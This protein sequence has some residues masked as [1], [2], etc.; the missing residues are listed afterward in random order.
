MKKQVPEG[1]FTREEQ[2]AELRKKLIGNTAF[3]R[4][5]GILYDQNTILSLF[6]QASQ[7]K[8]TPTQFCRKLGKITK[9]LRVMGNKIATL[10]RDG[11]QEA[12]QALLRALTVPGY[13]IP[14]EEI[15]L[16]KTVPITLIMFM[17]EKCMHMLQWIIEGDSSDL[18]THMDCRKGEKPY[19]RQELTER[20]FELFPS[21]YAGC[22]HRLLNQRYEG[23]DLRYALY[24]DVTSRFSI[25]SGFQPLH[26]NH[27]QYNDHTE[28]LPGVYDSDHIEVNNEDVPCMGYFAFWAE[29]DQK[30]AL[31][32][33]S[34]EQQELMGTWQF[35]VHP[36]VLKKVKEAPVFGLHT[37]DQ[38][39]EWSHSM[40][41]FESAGVSHGYGA[42]INPDPKD[43]DTYRYGYP[44]PKVKG[45]RV[46]LTNYNPKK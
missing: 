24:K 17:P 5:R 43:Y 21:L 26:I 13:R 34:R 14:G 9:D 27:G 42:V 7:G 1:K 39:Q 2:L 4:T 10:R 8:I 22:R 25:P 28:L 23:I 11:K 15:P 33:F 46:L 16:E 18:N 36:S 45:L 41:G 20:L 6:N 12:A 19:Y 35:H 31:S 38:H 30:T 3:G 40:S 32:P 37:E 29:G 44:L